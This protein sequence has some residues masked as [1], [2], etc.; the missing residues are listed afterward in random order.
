MQGSFFCLFFNLVE[1]VNQLTHIIS[2]GY[3]LWNLI[4]MAAKNVV[5]LQYIHPWYVYIMQACS[6][7]K[8]FSFVYARSALARAVLS[9]NHLDI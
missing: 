7:Q 8:E 2:K 4:D 6:Y 9:A 1:T 5:R 3:T